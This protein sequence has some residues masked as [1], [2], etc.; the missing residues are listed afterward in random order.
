MRGV[1]VARLKARLSEYL[2]AVRKGRDIV[3][4]DRDL[5]IA[6]IVPYEA[7]GTLVVRGPTTR[8]A[9]LGDVP[10]PPPV[11]LEVDPVALLLEDR[12]PVE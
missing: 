1:G 7:T 2:P 10:L 8:Y 12:R 6:R 5:P 4:M 11:P 9:T 3:V